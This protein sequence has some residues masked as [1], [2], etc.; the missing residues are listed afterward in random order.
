MSHE[1]RTPL[2]S[3][4][5]LAKLLADNPDGNLT[6]KQ[7]E[8]SQTIHAAGSDLLDLINDILDLSKVE[9]G[10]MEL[11]TTDVPLGDL[12]ERI[13]RAFRPVAEQKGLEFEVAVSGANVPPTIITDRQRLEQ[14]LRN[15]LSNAFKFTD[16][17][18]VTLTI[19]VGADGRP[20]HERAAQPRR[21][22]VWRSS[23]RTPGSG[24]RTTSCA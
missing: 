20:L 9:A 18:R 3:L 11:A 24:S 4:L 12:R 8:F 19:G 23:S 17:G 13:E 16:E 15:L 10:K 21:R 1:L 7:I 2:N 6:E 5:I 14:I 22:I